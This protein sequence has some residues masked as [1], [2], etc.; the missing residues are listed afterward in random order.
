MKKMILLAL[1]SLALTACATTTTGPKTL[2]L[3]TGFELFLPAGV[4]L[5]ETKSADNSVTYRFTSGKKELLALFL[6]NRATLKNNGMTR[7]RKVD[8]NIMAGREYSWKNA[9]G[10]LSRELLISTGKINWPVYAHF[11]YL[12]QNKD[13]A[14]TAD[15]IISSLK[16]LSFVR[17]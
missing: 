4:G 1:L 6:G 3:Q 10:S 13:D 9:D 12:N 15:G 7:D 11:Y 2:T 14:K 5:E 8:I 16:N 17:K